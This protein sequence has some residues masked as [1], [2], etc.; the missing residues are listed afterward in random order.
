MCHHCTALV[1]STQL[2]SNPSPTPCAPRSNCVSAHF[3]SDAHG[4]AVQWELAASEHEGQMDASLAQLTSESERQKMQLMM[5]AYWL[6][7]EQVPINK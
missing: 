6:C 1:H 3:A 2:P 7:K 5:V 4:L